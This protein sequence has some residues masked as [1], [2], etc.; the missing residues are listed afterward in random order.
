VKP[1]IVFFG[2]NLPLGFFQKRE[3]DLPSADLLLV[4][5]T[6]LKVQ[7]FA[8]T[9]HMVSGSAPRL[10]LNYERVGEVD[11]H[12]E[13]GFKFDRRNNYRDVELLA[14]IDD[15]VRLLCDLLGWRGEVGHS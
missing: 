7:P 9:M 15:G 8:D 2:E 10:L 6:S 13:L 14:S 4:L 3:V 12:S 5:G 1:D 11:D